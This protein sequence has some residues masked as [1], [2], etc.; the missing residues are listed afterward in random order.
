MTI[1]PDLDI[2]PLASR[3]GKFYAENA[4]VF[5]LPGP[6]HALLY[7]V[8][9]G[10]EAVN[11]FLRAARGGDLRRAASGETV[12]QE[13]SDFKFMLIVATFVNH[14]PTHVKFFCEPEPAKKKKGDT[15]EKIML[16]SILDAI[17]AATFTDMGA[18]DCA[19]G[20]IRCLHWGGVNDCDYTI[21]KLTERC[22]A[23]RSE[24][25]R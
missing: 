16:A 25:G 7:A 11:A 12:E 2:Y 6:Q 17:N 15:P 10:A 13:L 14:V 24:W 5:A 22:M 23:A 21:A 4:D 8:T 3:I 1:E 19:V 20:A 9:E 18:R